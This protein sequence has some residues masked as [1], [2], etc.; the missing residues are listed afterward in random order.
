MFF[1]ADV[2]A[3]LLDRAAVLDWLPGGEPLTPLDAAA[4]SGAAEL[5]HLA[6]GTRC[7]DGRARGTGDPQPVRAARW[8]PRRTVERDRQ[9]VP[10]RG[11]MIPR[12]AITAWGSR[13][14]WPTEEQIEQ[15]L[16][17]SQ[18]IVEVANDSYLGGE[19]VFRGGTCLHKLRLAEPL[20]Y[21]E[22]LDYVRRSEGGI[23]DITRAVGAIGGR[24]GMEV[25]TQSG[26]R[27][28]N[29]EA[30]HANGV[31][32]VRAHLHFH[33]CPSDTARPRSPKARSPVVLTFRQLSA[34]TAAPAPVRQGPR[35]SMMVRQVIQGWRRST[36]IHLDGS[37][38]PA[39]L[40]GGALPDARI[41]ERRAGSGST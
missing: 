18:L 16:L 27:H 31:H 23:A 12:P 39:R 8:S 9:R 15:D 26:R 13:A 29:S 5:I 33:E 28:T 20:R 10:R 24:L 34:A 19:L 2:A 36:L 7:L 6:A 38:Q 3:D 40:S 11:V 30:S 37:P 32:G 22:D 14:R 25:R 41:S 17:P 35:S 21:S 1:G 4:R